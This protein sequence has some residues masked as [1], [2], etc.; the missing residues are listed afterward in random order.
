MFRELLWRAVI[1]VGPTMS[2][3]I[4][5]GLIMAIL[6]ATTSVND[7]AVAF[8]PKGLAGVIAL[9]VSGNWMLGQLADFTIAV[10]AAIA[11]VA[12]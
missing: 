11:K 4:V 3:I 2:A 9:S 1:T 10:F 5:V 12:P 6:Q 7:Q 8:G